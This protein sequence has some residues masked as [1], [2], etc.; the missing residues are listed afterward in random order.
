[1]SDARMPAEGSADDE[2]ASSLGRY[3][4]QREV[5]APDFSLMFAKAK[6]EAEV[7]SG[8]SGFTHWG[9]GF[10][11]AATILLGLVFLFS[12]E[13]HH[14]SEALTAQ[15][16]SQT[17]WHSPSDQILSLAPVQLAAAEPVRLG[18]TKDIY[19]EPAP[20]VWPATQLDIEEQ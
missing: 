20:L 11:A 19:A 18:Y 13:P 12:A 17:F 7:T 2:V 15:L 5:P 14:E 16:L 8:S 9:I 10:G 3:F 6:A 4:D 1:M